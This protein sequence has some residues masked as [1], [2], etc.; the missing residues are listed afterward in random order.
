[1]HTLNMVSMNNEYRNTIWIFHSDTQIMI[2]NIV[3]CI[4]FVWFSQSTDKALR[5]SPSKQLGPS[6]LFHD[7]ENC[8][9][10]LPTAKIFFCHCN[11]PGKI[12][13][14]YKLV[15]KCWKSCRSCLACQAGNVWH[16][17]LSYH[18]NYDVI[19]CP[20][21]YV[22]HDIKRHLSSSVHH[23]RLVHSSR[24]PLHLCQDWHWR[25]CWKVR[26]RRVWIRNSAVWSPNGW[27]IQAVNGPVTS[28]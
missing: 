21:W 20:V 22:G 26:Q 3:I 25:S 18:S 28:L 24:H 19:S 16:A 27:R 15:F 8:C 13:W 6:L 5:C 14:P 11:H 10:K 12:I 4:V 2:Q 7:I 9:C 1:M 17:A 23:V